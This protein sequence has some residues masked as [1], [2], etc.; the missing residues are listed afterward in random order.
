MGDVDDDRVAWV[1]RIDLAEGAAD[2]LL[3]G[4]DGAEAA[5]LEGRLL[6]ALDLDPRDPGLRPGAAE[7]G[8]A[9]NGGAERQRREPAGEEGGA[10]RT[11][12]LFHAL[13]HRVAPGAWHIGSMLPS[14]WEGSMCQ[15]VGRVMRGPRLLD[16]WYDD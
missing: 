8:R 10:A 4:A 7:N 1:V 3:I 9:G 12:R 13:R 5:A 11:R 2:E 16:A 6:D 14:L 15:S